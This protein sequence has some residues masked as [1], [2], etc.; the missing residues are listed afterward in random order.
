MSTAPSPATASP[1]QRVLKLGLSIGLFVALC[2]MSECSAR[3]V[4][5]LSDAISVG[6]YQEHPRFNHQFT[7]DFEQTLKPHPDIDGFAFQ[8]NRQSLRHP[9]DLDVDKPEGTVRIFVCGDSFTEGY[10]Q[11]TTVAARLQ[12]ALSPWASERGLTLEVVNAGVGSYSPMLHYFVLRDRLL[13]L[14]PD[15]VV[16]L[17]DQTDAFDDAVRYA[18]YL[19]SGEDGE[20]LGVTSGMNILEEALRRHIEEHLFVLHPRSLIARGSRVSEIIRRVWRARMAGYMAEYRGAIS[21]GGLDVRDHIFP[22][23][24]AYN[25]ADPRVQ[26]W[27]KTSDGWIE[28]VVGLLKDQG[29]PVVIGVYPHEP[30]LAGGEPDA[31]TRVGDLA[32]RLDVPF[33][34]SFDAIKEAYDA[35]EPVFLKDD[36]HYGYPGIKAWTGDLV[37]WL[38]ETLPAV[39]DDS[40]D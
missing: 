21:L 13:P 27:R 34:S 1:R 35:G 18:P 16:L 23:K 20:L 36:L 8:T 17:P 4:A 37:P 32:K 9:T 19:R 14:A 15:A 31:L 6:R 7:P 30:Q 24:L 22:E 12:E 3:V 29:V 5:P 38:A 40:G 10:K 26:A 11:E 2:L 39:L 28:R 25:D 33:H